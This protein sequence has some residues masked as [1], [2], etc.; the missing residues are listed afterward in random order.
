MVI[1]EYTTQDIG[2]IEAALYR[3]QNY[4]A[5]LDDLGRIQCKPGYGEAYLTD[6]LNK[7]KEHGGQIFVAEEAGKIIGFTAGI[8]EEETDMHRFESVPLKYGL[9]TDVFVEEEYR[10]TGIGKQ[11]MT[12]IEQYFKDQ[13][14]DVALLRVIAQNTNAYKM[15]QQI[16]YVTREHELHKTLIT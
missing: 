6:L 12:V 4:L 5:S 11:L 15:Y 7:I 2:A 9:I 14:C 16:G 8:L 10:G 13:K 1:R 3:F